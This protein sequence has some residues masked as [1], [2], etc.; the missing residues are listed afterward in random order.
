MS[1]RTRRLYQDEPYLLEFE[2]RVLERLEHEGR[3]AVV[4]DET[5]FYAE[6]G[7]QPWDLGTLEPVGLTQGPARAPDPDGSGARVP[8]VAVIEHGTALLHLLERPLPDGGRGEVDRV[9]GRV[10]GTRRRDHR[11]QHHGQ[12]LLSRAFVELFGA[13]TV[14]FHLGTEVSSV[15]LDQA[16]TETQMAA[17]EARTNEIVAEARPV[18]VRTVTRAEALALGVSVP[19][20]A[21]DAVRLVE[22]QGF[23]LQPCG[24][25]HP[26]S[27]GEVGSVV[28]TGHE[29]YKGGSRVRFVCGDRA[30]HTFHEQSA[31]LDRLAAT[32]SS[33]RAALPEAV[34]RLVDQATEGRKDRERLLERALALEAAS[35]YN[36][37]RAKGVLPAVVVA[38][39]DARGPDE[40]QGL[41]QALV[42]QGPCVALLGTAHQGKAYLVF[43]QSPGA[44]R[45]IPGLLKASLASIGGRGGGKGDLARGGGDLVVG[46]E[47]ALASGAAALS[48]PAG[49]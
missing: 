46:L 25:T 35:L 9:R 2:A 34:E 28:I 20:Q 32:L 42:A 41:A 10:D 37:A 44:G 39:F 6:S 5:A 23:D 30:R 47:A 12:H 1:G 43:A 26:K 19:Q 31:I 3:P 11:Q 13:R 36:A 15:D 45:D 17:A 40:L 29:R 14:S 27:T 38:H 7:G 33:A 48:A 16:L 18:A 49:T 22:A 24:G 21:E 8:V 4:L